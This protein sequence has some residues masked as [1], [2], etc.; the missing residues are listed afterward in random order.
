MVTRPPLASPSVGHPS[1]RSSPSTGG[2]SPGCGWEV[3]GRSPN[4]ISPSHASQPMWRRRANGPYERW[5]I[6]TKVIRQSL[7]VAS[8][9]HSSKFADQL[10][11]HAVDAAFVPGI[12]RGISGLLSLRSEYDHADSCNTDSTQSTKAPDRGMC[13]S[14]GSSTAASRWARQR[15]A[16]SGGS[17]L[18][19]NWF[20]F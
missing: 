11:K 20:A 9:L 5:T 14:S 19:L 3:A 10:A 2:H 17:G 7:A 4:G 12:Q 16:V 6:A 13:V 1:R 15:F 8:N 18:C